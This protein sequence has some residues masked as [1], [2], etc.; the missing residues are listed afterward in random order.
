VNALLGILAASGLF[1]LF[2]WLQSRTDAGRNV[3]SCGGPDAD[4]HCTCAPTGD[5]PPPLCDRAEREAPAGAAPELI[6]PEL[7]ELRRRSADAHPR[8]SHTL[9]SRPSHPA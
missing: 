7:I 2:T 9:R 6:A 4:G 1:V 8:P 5:G 3:T